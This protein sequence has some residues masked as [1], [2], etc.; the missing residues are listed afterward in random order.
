MKR[1]VKEDYIGM[2]SP[3]MVY[4][5]QA[6]LSSQGQSEL[7]PFIILPILLAFLPLPVY[8]VLV[9]RTIS[10]TGMIITGLNYYI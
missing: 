2:D 5:R 8:L 7:P 10:S 4:T 3:N 6:C 1:V 9:E